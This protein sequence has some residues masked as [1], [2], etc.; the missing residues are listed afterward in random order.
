MAGDELFFEES[1]RHRASSIEEFDAEIRTF[2]GFGKKTRLLEFTGG[3]ISIPVYVNEFW[4]SKQRAAHSIHEISYRACFKPQL[5]RFFIHRLTRPGDVVYDPFLGRGTTVIEAALAGR[6]PLGCDVNPLSRILVLPRLDPPEATEVANRLAGLDLERP[7]EVW[8]D[9]L[10]FYHPKTLRQITHLRTYLLSREAEGRLD[11]VDAWI[12]MVATNRLTGHSRGFFSV[13][14]LP[15]NQAVSIEAQRRINE[16]RNQVPP[17]REIKRLIL[18]KTRS[19]LAHLSAAERKRLRRMA[20]DASIVTGSA[21]DTPEIP[22]DSVH[23]AVTS[24]PFLDTVDY[25]TD[26]WLRCWF[27]G[28]DAEGVQVW[29]IKEPEAWQAAMASTFRELRRVL[30]EGGIVAF[31]VGEV[32][33]GK[34]LLETLVV[35]AAIDAGLQ[36][37]MVLVNDQIFTKTSNCWGVENLRKGTNTNRIVVVQKR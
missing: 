32:R 28:I 21:N 36:P 1:Q 11:R 20:R 4:T 23:L 35:P 22:N 18:R 27:N 9:L 13:Y 25:R 3:G 5:P 24:P 37:R 10:V 7:V 34:I 19:L 33:N 8:E 17:E 16:K 2:A 12:R 29:R 31:E 26:N 14:T 30:V 15:P 6:R